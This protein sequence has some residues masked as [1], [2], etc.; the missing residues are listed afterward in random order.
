MLADLLDQLSLYFLRYSVLL[1]LVIAILTF[2]AESPEN[3]VSLI[4]LS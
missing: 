4:P 3:C 2:S 1:N